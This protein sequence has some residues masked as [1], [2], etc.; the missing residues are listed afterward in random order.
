MQPH[1]AGV[2]GRPFRSVHQIWIE[3]SSWRRDAT[4][5]SETGAVAL[6][7]AGGFEWVHPDSAATAMAAD[8]IDRNRRIDRSGLA[9]C[10]RRVDATTPLSTTILLIIARPSLPTRSP[11]RG[12]G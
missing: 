11:S 1:T 6:S 9:R 3:R 7:G 2:S 10:S 12:R 8:R 4:V 5:S